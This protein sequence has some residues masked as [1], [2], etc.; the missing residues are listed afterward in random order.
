MVF[1]RHNF[2]TSSIKVTGLIFFNFLYN[3]TAD[4]V[5]VLDVEISNRTIL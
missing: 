2:S 4:L 3:L 5:T 1:L